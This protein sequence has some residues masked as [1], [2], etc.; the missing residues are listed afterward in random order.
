MPAPDVPAP[1]TREAPAEGRTPA[2]TAR[3]GDGGRGDVPLAGREDRGRPPRRGWGPGWWATGAVV[4][5]FVLSR[6]AYAVAGVRFRWAHAVAYHQFIDSQA[7]RDDLGRS[8]WYDHTQ[9]PGL[10]LLWGLA[11][12]LSPDHPDRVLWPV[13]LACGLATALV[14][15]R[16][17]I[18]LGCRPAV[19]AA[20]AVAWVASPTAVL[21]ESYLLYTPFEVLGLATI[22]LLVARWADRGSGGAL[23]GA[24]AVAA[25]LALTRSTFHLVW[26]VGLV[27]LAAV[28]H[29]DRWRTVAVVGLVPLLLVGGWYTKNLVLFDQWGASSWMGV[30]LSRIT[31][32][33][34]PPAER[35]RLVADGTLSPYAAHPSFQ[36]FE[37]M[38]LAPPGRD[39]PG[40]GV[41]VLDDRQRAEGGFANLHH[42]DYL[43]VNEAALDD[44]AWVA[45]HRPGTYLAGIG[46]SASTTFTA[47]SGWFGYG[48][49]TAEVAGAV[50]VERALLGAWEE[51]P[52]VYGDR[53]GARA[54]QVEWV[55]V[56]AYLLV[57][58]GAAMV[59]A[60]RRAWRRP[61]GATAAVAFLWGT[62][63][64]LTLLT[65]LIEYGETNRFRTVTDACVLAMGAWLVAQARA[66]AAKVGGA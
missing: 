12:K 56:V 29:R 16:L 40:V 23:A 6:T 66:R 30:S 7:L 63:V 39:G 22:A 50:T 54:G 37:D 42:R 1:S 38:G 17:L 60:R 2:W 51:P 24:L 45:R 64:Y 25:A 26:V 44:A 61:D 19:A 57:L 33:Q 27:A 52:P 65:L 10:N 49:N 31:V 47:S 15:L 46:R 5:G 58:V 4:A 28:V 55:V 43:A 21:V 20:L 9:P 32:E 18:R 3:S 53:R 36:S 48:P 41:P 11:L 35:A 62:A 14:L 34:L 59:L 13:F 8:L